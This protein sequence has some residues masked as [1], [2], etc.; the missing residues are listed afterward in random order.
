MSV[1]T[2]GLVHLSLAA[3]GLALGCSGADQPGGD[4]GSEEIAETARRLVCAESSDM[5]MHEEYDLVALNDRLA[6]APDLVE[7]SGVSHV[8]SCDDARRVAAAEDVWVGGVTLPEPGEGLPESEDLEAKVKGG[9]AS[10]WNNVAVLRT[11]V[12]SC[13]ATF[14]NERVL[15]TAAHCLTNSADIRST[16]GGTDWCRV[17]ISGGSAA[18]YN[19]CRFWRHSGYAGSGDGNDDIG[20]VRLPA[21]GAVSGAGMRL[22]L[23]YDGTTGTFAFRGQGV[24]ESGGTNT[25]TLR[26]DA[27]NDPLRNFGIFLW[28]EKVVTL[29]GSEATTLC[30]GDSGGAAIINHNSTNMA[31]AVVSNVSDFDLECWVARLTDPDADCCADNG[32]LQELTRIAP[33]IDWIEN[34]IGACNRFGSGSTAYARGL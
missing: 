24:T 5:W 25:G 31:V 2:N 14:I 11:D 20:L 21:A 29:A 27:D 9:V 22:W 10:G 1:K 13:T 3:I 16:T 6:A 17:T 30:S 12:G 28:P 19:D 23:S 26:R 34:R 7:R 8:T 18:Q 32:A 4:T 15:V 33:K